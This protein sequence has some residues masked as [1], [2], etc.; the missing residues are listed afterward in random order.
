MSEWQLEA[1]NDG[2]EWE[3]LKAQHTRCGGV[4]FSSWTKIE[5]D[6]DD[7]AFY[8]LT[9][10][11][12]T[13][14]SDGMAYRYFRVQDMENSPT[15]DELR[16][17]DP[18]DAAQILGGDLGHFGNGSIVSDGEMELGDIELELYGHLRGGF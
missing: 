17:M 11:A 3:V 18:H 8:E 9:V 12:G 2:K 1:S 4:R 13:V 5:E 14:E 10:I 6:E 15:R 7:D 16:R